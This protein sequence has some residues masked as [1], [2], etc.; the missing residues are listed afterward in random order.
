MQ[1]DFFGMREQD[2]A[3]H[4]KDGE[5]A[6]IGAWRVRNFGGYHQSMEQGGRWRFY[7]TGF[8]RVVAGEHVECSLLRID[9]TT[10]TVPIDAAG[11]ITVMGRRY[12]AESWAH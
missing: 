12:G 3:A 4:L 2:N 6:V 8:G 1:G 11:C 7:V 9:G 5:E 10:E